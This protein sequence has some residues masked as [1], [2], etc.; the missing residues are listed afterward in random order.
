VSECDGEALIM[1]RPWPIRGSCAMERKL[2]EYLCTLGLREVIDS[3]FWVALCFVRLLKGAVNISDY[4]YIFNVTYN[5]I[6][7]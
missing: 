7:E 3:S 1:R 4:L 5:M 2:S 6:N